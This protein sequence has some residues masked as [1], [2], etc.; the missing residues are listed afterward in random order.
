MAAMLYESLLLVGVLAVAVVLPH[1]L[2][3]AARGAALA[4]GWLLGHVFLVLAVYFIWFWRQG[5]QT[6]AMK[7]W[8]IRLEPADGNRRVTVGQA[9]LRYSLAWPC[10]LTGIGIAWSLLDPDRQFLHDRL[11][12]T[13]LVRLIGAAD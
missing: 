7:T 10:V 4:G 12:G 3:G 5:G 6:L 9:L 8:R 11:S 2:I 1:T 13:R